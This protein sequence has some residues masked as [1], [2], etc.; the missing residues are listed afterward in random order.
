M[1][2][3]V[4]DRTIAASFIPPLHFFAKKKRTYCHHKLPDTK[5]IIVN[6]TMAATMETMPT[7]EPAP[8]AP[9]ALERLR[10][11]SQT[12]ECPHCGK[13]V[14]TTIE[15]RGKGMQRFMDVMFWPLPGRR[16]WWETTTWRC[17]ACEASL[18]SQKNG[19][20]LKV[21]H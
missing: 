10:P 15:G 8:K 20:E 17:G 4:L 3:L 1:V 19:K 5:Y 14:K 6:S 7:Q 12:I 11:V 18:A 9:V 16:N 21:A 2:V 13:L